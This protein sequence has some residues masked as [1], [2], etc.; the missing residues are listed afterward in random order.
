MTAQI[1]NGITAMPITETA[2]STQ[3]GPRSRSISRPAKN[4][5]NGVARSVAADNAIGR[6]NRRLR[7]RFKKK[8]TA[9]TIQTHPS[10][11]TIGRPSSS[12]CVSHGTSARRFS[13]RPAVPMTTCWPPGE[14]VAGKSA[15][16]IA[17][18]SRSTFA[19]SAT[20]AVPATTTNEPSMT[21]VLASSALPSTTTTSCVT[22]PSMRASPPMT[23]TCRAVSPACS[24]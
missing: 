21:A 14:K 8:K 11:G 4:A 16:P 17:T 19:P 5:L 6:S 2:R 7:T 22:R 9:A 18:T 13:P 24:V 12:P 1:R 23:T 15:P 10:H 3:T 20:D